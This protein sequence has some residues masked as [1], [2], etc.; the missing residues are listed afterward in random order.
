M[1]SGNVCLLS[2]NRIPSVGMDQ[3]TF[4]EPTGCLP[5]TQGSN[6]R[7]ICHQTSVLPLKRPGGQARQWFSSLAFSFSPLTDS[8]SAIAWMVHQIESNRIKNTK[9]GLHSKETSLSVRVWQKLKKKK[10]YN[11]F[12][13]F[14]LILKHFFISVFLINVNF[15]FFFKFC[16]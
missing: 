7:H 4:Q 6:T 5:T 11:L 8:R 14:Y 3:N 9:N 16:N 12:Q 2:Q 13:C 1:Y 15:Y 10:S